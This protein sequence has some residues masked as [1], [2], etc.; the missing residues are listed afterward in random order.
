MKISDVRIHRKQIAE[1]VIAH[2][3]IMDFS[4]LAAK[5]SVRK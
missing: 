1:K 2:A 5:T 3:W 4:D